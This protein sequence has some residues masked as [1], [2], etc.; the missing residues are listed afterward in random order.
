M[1]DALST[2]MNWWTVFY[3]DHT[4]VSGTIRYLHLAGIMIGGGTALAA[5]RL[6]IGARATAEG[7]ARVLLALQ[8]AHRVVL[9]SLAAVGVTGVLMFAAD[10]ETFLASRTFAVKLA[11]VLLLVVNGGALVSA[12]RGIRRA[13]TERSWVRL[14]A[15]ARISTA[16][17]LL[18]LML[19]VLL[20]FAA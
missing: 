8:E 15:V 10:T 5:D 19:G 17:W 20:A 13:G 6:V 4:A 1:P 16:L 18:V 14:S 7:R 2:V 11:G 12:E 3:G 9:P